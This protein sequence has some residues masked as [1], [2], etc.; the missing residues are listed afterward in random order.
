DARHLRLVLEGSDQMR[1]PPVAKA[2][3]LAPAGVPLADPL[4]VA[5]PK[6]AHLVVDRPGHDRLRGLVLCLADAPTV[7]GLMSAL[8]PA[9][10]APAPRSPPAPARRLGTHL[11]PPGLGVGEV[12]VALG[13]HR[14]PRHE[15]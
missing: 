6:G 14:P 11:P 15:Q 8:A 1:T 4:G 2:Q 9:E 3:V 12:Q 13:P 7:A 10:L 5:H